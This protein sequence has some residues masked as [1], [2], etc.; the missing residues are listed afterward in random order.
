MRARPSDPSVQPGCMRAPHPAHAEHTQQPALWTAASQSLWTAAMPRSTHAQRPVVPRAG[1]HMPCTS[2]PTPA[3][4]SMGGSYTACS[5]ACNTLSLARNKQPVAAPGTRSSDSAP[6]V[7]LCAQT[8]KRMAHTQQR[9]CRMH[10]QA[11]VRACVQVCTRMAST[12][13][14]SAR[15]DRCRYLQRQR[16]VPRPPP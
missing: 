14:T 11:C 5:A 9:K 10:A 3:A 2:S 4:H 6:M 16:A 1:A 7:L 12:E 8:R 13:A 15:R